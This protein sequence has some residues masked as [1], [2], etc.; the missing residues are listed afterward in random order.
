MT[1]I[2]EQLHTLGALM[3]TNLEIKGVTGL[4]SSMG[5]TT[6]ANKILEIIYKPGF[7]TATIDGDITFG[8]NYHKSLTIG[9]NGD[10]IVD[11]GDGTRDTINNLYKTITHVYTDGLPRHTVQFIGEVTVIGDEM[12]NHCD[13][14]SVFISN[15]VTKIGLNAFAGRSQLISVYLPNSLQVLEVNSFINCS[16]LATIYIPE[17]VTQVNPQAFLDCT[18]MQNYQLYWTGDQIL[19]YD[20]R[21]Y[22]LNTNTVF[23]I[24]AGTEQAYIDKGYPSDRLVERN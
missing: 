5:L 13:L 17:S 7:V 8:T 24:P 23:T 19:T 11:W 9:T 21:A 22:T 14:K 20:N 15:S 4:T 1:S 18:N 12:F 2:A 10:V 16:G 6:L 3:K